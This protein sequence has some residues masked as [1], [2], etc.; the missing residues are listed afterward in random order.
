M[1]VQRMRERGRPNIT[2]DIKTVRP[3]SYS[4]T[5]TSKMLVN[6]LLF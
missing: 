4:T 5:V 1:K 3:F 2:S 6:V